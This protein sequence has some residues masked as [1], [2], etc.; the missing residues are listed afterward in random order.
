MP[1]DR[2]DRIA[3]FAVQDLF[4]WPDRA[5]FSYA[6]SSGHGREILGYVL[7]KDHCGSEYFA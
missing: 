5:M 6:Y 4:R 7:G 1:P 3:A 2:S